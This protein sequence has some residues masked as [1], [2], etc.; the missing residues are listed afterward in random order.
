MRTGPGAARRHQPAR[1][2]NAATAAARELATAAADRVLGPNPFVG[3]RARDLAASARRIAALALRHPG[4][5]L[6][7]YVAMASELAAAAADRNAPTPAPGDRR[8]TDPAWQANP[9][10]RFALRG[11]LAWGRALGTFVDRSTLGEKHRERVRFVAALLTDALA[12]TN[13]LLGNPAAIRKV[14]DTGGASLL[15]GLRNML[16]DLIANRGMPAQVDM[17]AFRPGTNVAVSPGAV[18][19]RNEVAELIQYAPTTATVHACPHLIVPPQ[20]NKFYVFD[21]AR[22]KSIVEFLV[23]RGFQVFIL[24]WRNPTPAQRDWDMDTYVAALLE[25]IEAAR[26]ISGHKDVILHGAC[27]G[28]MTLSALLGHLAAKKRRLVRA[29][30]LMVGVLD[31]SERSQIGLFATAEAVTAAKRKSMAK[32][33]L[34]GSDMAR[35]FAWMRANDLV[36]NYWV[37]N[38]L[39]GN[40]PPA[41]DVLY[42]NNDTTRLP[43]R[44]HGQL[45]DIF[46]KNLFR[47]PGALTVLGTPIDLARVDCD[48]F[49][50]AGA[51][52]H[53]TP[54]KGVY[55]T[56]RAFGGRNEF[57]LSSSGHIQSLINPPGNPRAK[58]F[59]NP[60]LPAAA[61]DWLGGARTMP[62]SWWEHWSEWLAA[63]SG[64][65][66]PARAALGNARHRPGA[67]AP[68]TYVAEP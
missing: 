17:K 47:T 9:A 19:F 1:P 52:D 10:Y 51:S 66:R 21:L 33:V 6:E 13:T 29:A 28:A 54:W 48:K 34:S 37:N 7:Q 46:V 56:A 44:F 25:A 14:I 4:L 60:A 58:Y 3:L 40:P 8:F 57:I 39:L 36:W 15:A 61:D 59:V 31:S 30:T 11:Y 43:A 20:I 64:P 22:G 16:A 12:P 62:D 50:V 45:L 18:V 24:S 2:A 65:K 27:S 26:D 41:F 35:V 5:L 32:G 23:G 53:I 38:Y 49:V 42:W 63:R 68:G 67:P 55:G